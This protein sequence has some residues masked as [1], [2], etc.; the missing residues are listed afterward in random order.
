[1][2]ASLQA[3]VHDPLWLLARQ[4]QF[5]EF[6]AEDRASPTRAKVELQH[7]QIELYFPGRPDSGSASSSKKKP[8]GTGLP[9]ETWVE[10]EPVRKAGNYRE[11]AEAGVQFFRLL[12][13]ELSEKYR[14]AFLQKYALES[15]SENGRRDLDNDSLRF[16]AVMAG[17]VIDG[18]RLRSKFAQIRD[19]GEVAVLPNEPPFTAIEQGDRLSV[20]TAMTDWLDWYDTLF[21]QSQDDSAWVSERMEYEFAVSAPANTSSGAKDELVLV[22][23]EYAEGH[24]DWYSFE[25]DRDTK[26]RLEVTGQPAP[27][28]QMEFVPSPI[29]F[30]GMPAPR[31]WEFEDAGVNFG[32]VEAAPED[33][34][35]LL[36]TEFALIYGNDF[37]VIP[38]DLAVGSVCQITSLQVL[39]TFGELV[40]IG[41]TSQA[42]GGTVPWRMFCLSSLDERVGAKAAPLDFL[43]LPPVLG[44]SL[45][46]PPIEEVLFLRD[47]MAN[48]AWA[49]EHIVESP[50]GRPLN[51]FEAFQEERRRREIAE[52][53]ST[54]PRSGPL[55]Y[56]LAS[57][58]PPYWVPLIPFHT[59]SKKK[60][61]IELRLGSLTQPL[62]H[63]LVKS[64][65]LNEEEVPR[66]GARVTRAYQ[67]ARWIDGSIHLWVGRRKWPGRGE[68][69][70][71]LRFDTVEPS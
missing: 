62:G 37:F 27:P 16:L 53:S 2:T 12:G 67:Y 19:V 31:W 65:A 48:M 39:N 36:L 52:P 14:A 7:S 26:H 22:A 45:E 10:R 61:D 38:I 68:G 63:L 55:E 49:V 6:Q 66:E 54:A 3:R 21:N 13:S 11:A 30:R 24:L 70:S 20:V 50:L 42:D 71:G 47:E 35:R 51:R 57:S 5:G 58:V 46:S 23:S 18:V 8:Y 60:R 56:R 69:S 17:R 1:M 64:L 43:F 34:A 32:G 28:E 59:Q 41:P 15:P 40:N 33:L 9:L 4:W 44:T 29:H 25:F